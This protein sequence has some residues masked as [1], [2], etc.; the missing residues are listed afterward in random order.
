MPRTLIAIA[1]AFLL[2]G[3]SPPPVEGPRLVLSGPRLF[4]PLLAELAKRHAART[5][6]VRI[7][8][9][10]SQPGR[11]VADAREGLTDV[12][13]VGRELRPDETGVEARPLARDGL[14]FIVHR[15]NSLASLTEAQASGLFTR[16][17]INWR[18]IGGA[19]RPVTV[20]GLTDGRAARVAFLDFL[21]LRGAQVRPEPAVASSEQAAVAV[22]ARPGAVGYVSLAGAR[23]AIKAGIIRVVPLAGT[24]PNADTISTGKYP[25][26]R[27]VVLVSRLEPPPAVQA[28]LDFAL[29]EENRALL[30]E[31][32]LVPGG[33]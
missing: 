15:S 25:F 30:A 11:A 23:E 16:L 2:A 31:Q 20:V 8:H 21:G 22:A 32:G 4:Q 12:A 26:V 1:A 18:E 27:T 6:G 13:I 5:P 10:T 17:Y 7:D 19:D 33:P 28:F 14:G 9:E 24:T 29:S 3:C